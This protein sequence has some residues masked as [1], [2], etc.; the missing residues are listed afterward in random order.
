VLINRVSVL[1]KPSKHLDV[2]ACW[3]GGGTGTNTHL[4]IVSDFRC[5]VVSVKHMCK[6]SS[7]WAPS[8]LPDE[9]KTR[10][11]V[12]QVL[13]SRVDPVEYPPEWCRAVCF[14]NSEGNGDG[15]GQGDGDDESEGESDEGVRKFTCNGVC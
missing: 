5:A 1:S 6:E 9:L 15:V 10:L 13:E 4:P 12:P 8:W 2:R 11:I 3:G 14:G 7:G